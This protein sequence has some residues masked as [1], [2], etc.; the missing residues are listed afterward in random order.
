MKPT[1]RIK[2]I[3]GIEY[4]YEE[5]PYYDPVSKQTR[6][7]SRYLGRNVDGE[8]VRMRSAPDE[9]IAMI[10]KP[11]VAVV[12]S[13]FDY[14]SI[15]LLQ[16]NLQDLHLDQYLNELLSETEVAM[17]TALTFNRLIRPLAM[18]HID[19]WYAGTTLALDGPAISLS[20]QRIS[21]LLEKIGTSNIP[22]ALMGRLLAENNTQRTLVYDITS[23]SSYS[24][25]IQLLEYGYSR[26]ALTLPQ[27]NLSLI[28]DKTSAY[29]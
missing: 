2:R 15:F 29:Q 9:V 21:E 18:N 7:T 16:Q 4:W 19:A 24:S 5:T 25:L 6:H 11:E 17:V 28:M 3:N 26:D 20:G 22:D 12:R 8:P 23:L 10:R 14:G 13:S 1:R 27:I